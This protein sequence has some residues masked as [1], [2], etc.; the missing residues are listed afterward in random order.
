MSLAGNDY[1]C[2][3]EVYMQTL[4]ANGLHQR[5]S[6]ANVLWAHLLIGMGLTNV[7]RTEFSA[8][9]SFN[10]SEPKGSGYQT[11]MPFVILDGSE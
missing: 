6:K 1:I 2:H 4:D 5:Y 9:S 8:S 3:V 7:S 11:E 10:T